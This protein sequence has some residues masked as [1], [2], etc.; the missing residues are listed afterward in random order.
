MCD[1]VRFQF[2]VPVIYLGMWPATHVNSVWP[3]LR[4]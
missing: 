3:S 2:S 1:R 4:G